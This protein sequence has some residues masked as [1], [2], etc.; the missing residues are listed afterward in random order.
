[1]N[2]EQKRRT[3]HR[4]R[5]EYLKSWRRCKTAWRR[6]IGECTSLNPKPFRD[7]FISQAW[8][9]QVPGA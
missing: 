5:M 6:G 3:R 4:S 2:H 1:M 9:M 7:W 8:Q